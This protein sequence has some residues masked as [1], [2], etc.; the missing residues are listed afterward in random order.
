MIFGTLTILGVGYVLVNVAVAIM[1]SYFLSQSTISSVE[2]VIEMC[3]LTFFLI[4]SI[5]MMMVGVVLIFGGFRYYN[6]DSQ[7]GVMF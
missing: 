7:R 1:L 3:G 2:I 4:A 6:R 5:A